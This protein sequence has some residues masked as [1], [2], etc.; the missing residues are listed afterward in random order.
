[1]SVF[2][3]QSVFVIGYLLIRAHR[4]DPICRQCLPML[5]LL[6]RK[7]ALLNDQRHVNFDKIDEMPKQIWAIESER[8]KVNE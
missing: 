2:C 1:M 7:L 5:I 6:R 3:T 8:E 4:M